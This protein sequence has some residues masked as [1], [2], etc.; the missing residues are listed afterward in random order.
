MVGGEA[1]NAISKLSAGQETKHRWLGHS[2]ETLGAHLKKKWQI[3]DTWQRNMFGNIQTQKQKIKN[4]LPKMHCLFKSKQ[5]CWS[6]G[7]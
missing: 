2:A 1:G 7:R 6:L 3:N 4:E 5:N